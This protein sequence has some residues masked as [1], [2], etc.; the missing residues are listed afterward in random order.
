MKQ[1]MNKIKDN[2]QL[3]GLVSAVFVVV[4]GIVLITVGKSLSTSDSSVLRN[5]TVDGLSFENADISCNSG[6]CTF[7]VD[8]YNENKSTYT[9]KNIDLNFKQEDNSVLTLVGYI[10][11][12]LESDEGRKLTASIDR[13]ISN[14]TNLEYKINK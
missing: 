11:E 13:D 6:V 5:Q 3:M 4:L 12:T 14:S 10:G 8:V 7:T 9:L 1:I 2:K